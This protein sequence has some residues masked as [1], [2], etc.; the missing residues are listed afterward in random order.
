[1]LRALGAGNK[2]IPPHCAGYRA[3]GLGRDHPRGHR[4]R[5]PDHLA[6]DRHDRCCRTPHG[7]KTQRLRAT[8]CARGGRRDNMSAGLALPRET[9][10]NRRIFG[11]AVS[12]LAATVIVKIVATGKEFVVAGIYGRSDAMDAFL[13]A[14]LIPN[15]LVNLI[16]ESMNQALIPTLIRV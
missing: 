16:A 9:G 2:G 12:V 4:R 6:A 14:F 15:L 3:G 10:V 13:A 7:R 11:A 8:L 5:E 1:M